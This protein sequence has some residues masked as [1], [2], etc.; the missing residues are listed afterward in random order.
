MAEEFAAAVRLQAVSGER[1]AFAG[2][3]YGVENRLRRNF[4]DGGSRGA[5]A[6]IL[7]EVEFAAAAHLAL[8]ELERGDLAFGLRIR[9]YGGI[10]SIVQLSP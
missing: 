1:R 7:T 3:C 4:G 9:D 8:D 5:D 10:A 6:P 2:L